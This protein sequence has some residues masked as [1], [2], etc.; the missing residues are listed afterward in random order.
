MLPLPTSS[1]LISTYNWPESLRAVL[2]SVRRQTH[3]PDEVIVADDGSRE[4]TR[5]MLDEMRAAFPRPLIHVWHEDL[6]FRKCL[7]WNKAIE[8]SRGEVIV[9][10]DGDCVIDRRFVEDHLRFIQ[11]GAFTC[12]G[13][14]L[15]SRER[16]RQLLAGTPFSRWSSGVSNKMNALRIPA[17]WN[18]FRRSRAKKAYISKGCN[19]AFWRKDLLAVNG[20]NEAIT[21][22]GREDAELEVR[23]MKAGVERQ[24]LKFGGV[25]YHLFHKENDRSR[26]AANIELLNRALASDKFWTPDGIVKAK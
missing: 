12:G 4:E 26:D 13:R 17:F 10:I 1:L 20:Y 8:R 18:L 7:I 9:Q 15:L 6:G 25:E 14:V 3:L 21:G 16:T 11:A 22:W 2:E 19:M 24:V 5:A 23:L